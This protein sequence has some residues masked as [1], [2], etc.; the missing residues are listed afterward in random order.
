MATLKNLSAPPSEWEPRGIPLPLMM[1]IER[2]G[3]V[4][5]NQ[6]KPCRFKR[7]PFRL[8]CKERKQNRLADHLDLPGPIQFGDPFATPFQLPY[9]LTI[10]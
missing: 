7:V 6:K 10:K 9:L 1:E 3:I 2:K 4:A 8:L 5:G